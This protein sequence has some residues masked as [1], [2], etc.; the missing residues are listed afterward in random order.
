[1]S[2]LFPTWLL[3]AFSLAESN[4]FQGSS[5]YFQ[6][7]SVCR[8]SYDL[9]K[10]SLLVSL[11]SV[12]FLSTILPGDFYL[13]FRFVLPDRTRL[14]SLD[15]PRPVNSVSPKVT[16][17]HLFHRENSKYTVARFTFLFSLLDLSRKHKHEG[18]CWEEEEALV[19]IE[20]VRVV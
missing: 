10:H 18:T 14:K 11:D 17:K 7:G 16:C 9:E 19:F 12:N 4:G 8:I 3:L 20:Q 13:V 5:S 6:F 1:M 15:H 2:A